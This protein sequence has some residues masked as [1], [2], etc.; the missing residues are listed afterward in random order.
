MQV[1]IL[2]RRANSVPEQEEKNVPLTLRC[3]GFEAPDTFD[4]IIV[5][6]KVTLLVHSFTRSLPRDMPGLTARDAAVLLH[7]RKLI[8]CRVRRKPT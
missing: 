7:R 2:S 3:K 5:A 6:E 4:A 1:Q 8:A